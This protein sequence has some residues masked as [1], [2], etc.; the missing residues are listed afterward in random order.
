MSELKILVLEDAVALAL[1]EREVMMLCK[2]DAH[3][4]EGEVMLFVL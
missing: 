1:V 3:E 4:N 2:L